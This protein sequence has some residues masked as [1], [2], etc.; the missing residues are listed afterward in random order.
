MQEIY[1]W[2]TYSYTIPN[3]NVRH[4]R[5]KT[6]TGATLTKYYKNIKVTRATT[7]STSTSSLDFGS[8]EVKTSSTKQASI[9]FNNTT[10]PQQ[11]TGTCTNGNFTVTPKSVNDTGTTTIDVKYNPQQPGKH[12]GTVTLS[13]NGKTVSFTVSGTSLATYNFSAQASPNSENYGSASASVDVDNETITSS[14]AS[15]TAEATF[16]ATAKEG[17]EFVGW[18]TSS[19]ATSY[20]STANPY[21]TTISNSAHATTATKTLYAIFRPVFRF[22]VAAEKIY[23]HGT[24]SATVT[25]KKILGEPTATSVSTQATFIATPKNGATF[26]GWYSDREHTQLV[27]KDATYTPTIKNNTVGYTQNL[28]LYAWF[29]CNQTL[30]WKNDIQNF[31]LIK[32]TTADCSAESDAGLSVTYKSSNPDVASVDENGIVTGN[33]A[34]NDKVEITVSQEGNDEYN[35][36]QVL[37]RTFYVLQKLQAAFEVSGFSGNSP[38]LKVGETATITLSNVDDDFTFSSSDN[39]VVS[40]ARNGDVLTLTALKAGYA[41]VA[42]SQPAN[43]THNAAS[44]EYNITVV[45]HQGGLSVSLPETMKVGETLKDFW[46]TN[47]N[48]VPVV[49]ESSAA[50]VLSYADGTLSAVGEGT[51]VITVS[52]AENDKWTGENRQ[53]TITV[54]KVSNTLGVSIAAMETKVGNGIA[55]SLLNQNNTETPVIATITEQELSSEVN[56]GAEVISY[57]DG[58]ITAKNAGK[59]KITFSQSASTKYEAFASSTYEITVTKHQ[60]P[61]SLTLNG[62]S[63]LSINLKYGATVSLAYSSVHSE[64]PITV[65]RTSGSHTT[66]SGNTITAGNAAGTDIYEVTQPETYKYEKGY[67]MFSIRVNNTNEEVGYVLYDETVYSRDVGGVIHAYELSGPGE[68]LYYSADR[69][70]GAIYYH[71]YAEYSIDGSSWIV[72]HDNT[73]IGTSY[74]D[75]S[76]AIPETARYVRFRN[77]DGGTLN[78]HIKNVKVPRKTYVRVSSDKTDFGT[79]YTGSTSQASFTV[80]YSTTNGGNIHVNSSNPNFTVSSEELAVDAHSDGTRTFTINYTPNPNQLGEESALITVSDLFYTQEITLK[81]V[82]A[83]RDNTLKVVGEQNLKVGDAVDNVYSDKNSDAELTVSLSRDGVVSYDATSNRLTAVGE[84][85]VIVTISQNANDHYHGVSKTIAV[86]VSKNS[87]T[88]VMSVDKT[89]LKVGETATVNFDGKNSDGVVTATY[90]VDGIVEYHNGEIVALKAGNTRITLT[91][92]ATVAH[93]SVSQSFDIAVTKHDQTLQWDNTL[94]GKELEL[95]VGQTIETNT[96]TASSGLEVTYSSS[97]PAALSVDPTTGKLTAISSGVNI[98]ITATQAGN[99]K[100][101]ETSITR[102][103]T[104][105]SKME[106]TIITSLSSTETNE[107][108]IGGGSVTIGCVTPITMDNFKITGEEGIVATTFEN[109]TLSITPMK[110]GEVTIT[111]TKGEDDSYYAVNETYHIQVLGAIANLTPRDAPVFEYEEYDEITLNRTLSEGHSTLTL[112]FDTEISKI[113]D[114]SE[115][116]AAQLA[117][118]TYN[119][120]DG[121]TLYFQKVAEGQMVANQP[122]VVYLPNKIE[123]PTWKN[124]TVVTP[125]AERIEVNNWTMQGNYTPGLDMEGKYGIA[126][127]QFRLGTEG[128]YIDAYTAYFTFLGRENVRARVAVMDEGGNTTY[129]GELKDGVLQTEEG[130][131]GLDGVQQNQLRKGINIVRMKDGKVRKILK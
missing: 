6:K 96:A 127:G 65:S 109:N 45:R 77:A 34:S 13:M 105:I 33:E 87:N 22:S 58:I 93:T 49:V 84:G 71:L 35:A 79:I 116:Y 107:L 10:Y 74:K 11:V 91:Q 70:T 63:A 117:L 5:F 100:Y 14:N 30:S 129:I 72:A 44:A 122:Y 108:R 114:N 4:I 66:L 55:V 9:S 67:A 26:E 31:N 12:E 88:L 75:F 46:N 40:I 60:N 37:V 21:K 83:K 52:Q 2:T 120:A 36:A 19:T 15:E 38:A 89:N 8:I 78:K 86:N 54:S 28:T 103:F 101:N 90:S 3:V 102:S 41:T 85:S 56:D 98:I 68:I 121:Y 20:E 18:G 119:K 42:L 126:G 115:A 112:P 80:D 81:A 53:Q 92:A 24:V 16:T 32:G 7:L 59:A 97:N 76:C 94:S 124:V 106:A 111:L 73:N 69:V 27:S 104:V 47:N 43:T 95:N 82:A 23:D 17:Y 110:K 57:A 131:Y 25:D 61:I 39:T 64:T 118:V 128:S 51:A 99:E 1:N 62:G 50:N 48:E 130:I 113:S 125:N 29:K 123:N